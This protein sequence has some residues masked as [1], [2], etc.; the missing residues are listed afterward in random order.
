MNIINKIKSLFL[1]RKEIDSTKDPYEGWISQTDWIEMNAG[2]SETKYMITNDYAIE[3]RLKA[4]FMCFKALVIAEARSES[5]HFT[6]ILLEVVSD[7]ERRAFK[8]SNINTFIKPFDKDV[9]E[10][11][12]RLDLKQYYSLKYNS[13]VYFGFNY[14]MNP[15]DSIAKQ[16]AS[17]HKISHEEF[18]KDDILQIPKRKL[19]LKNEKRFL[20][21][22]K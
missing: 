22:T 8:D 7:N 21:K 17:K 11:C 18:Y 14:L 4:G 16:E 9:Y 12:F 5:V 19:V 13:K 6:D 1:S 3:V 15:N 10:V 20:S 2:I